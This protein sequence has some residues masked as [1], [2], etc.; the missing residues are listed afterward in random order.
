MFS[1][2]TKV[3][4][5]V[6]ILTTYFQWSLQFEQY[7]LLEEEFP[8]LETEAPHLRLGHLDCLAGSAASH[9]HKSDV[10]IH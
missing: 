8:G 5:V 9:C 7:R 2:S 4:A 3:V 10:T 1:H 6:L